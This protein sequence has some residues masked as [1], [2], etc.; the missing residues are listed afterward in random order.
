MTRRQTML[1]DFALRQ[2]AKHGFGLQAWGAKA[3]FAS[4]REDL[5]KRDLR[6][7]QATDQRFCLLR[8]LRAR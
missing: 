4:L 5:S 6:Y 2:D 3:T 8:R 1:C 7:A